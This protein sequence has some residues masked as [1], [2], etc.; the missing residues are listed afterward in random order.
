MVGFFVAGVFRRDCGIQLTSSSLSNLS[1]L[2]YE[3]GEITL[4][5]SEEMSIES[6]HAM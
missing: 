4:P 6:A 1:F 2:I 5:R 3:L